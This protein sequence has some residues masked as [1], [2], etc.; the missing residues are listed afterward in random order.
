MHEY[1]KAAINRLPEEPTVVEAGSHYGQFVL[2]VYAARPKA[3]IIAIE[4]SPTN[5]A[6]LV[7]KVPVGA[8]IECINAC[9]GA[10]SGST[11]MYVGTESR[12]HSYFRSVAKHKGGTLEK[13]TVRMVTL[14]EVC[15]KYK[16][17]LL[18]LDC[19]GGE[20]EAMRTFVPFSRVT[21]LL[22]TWHCK[23]EPFNTPEY[24]ELRACHAETLDKML[25]ELVYGSINENG[26]HMHQVWRAV[27]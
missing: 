11:T 20:Y 15:P 8:N 14:D 3:R 5:Y 26:K 24:A 16:I 22:I 18:R 7:K 6:K 12:A 13:D 10:H 21:E 9:V 23:P 4:G 27:P 1:V 17:D 2:D 25:F 19:Y